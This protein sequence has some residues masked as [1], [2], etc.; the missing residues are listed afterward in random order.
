MLRLGQRRIGGLLG[1]TLVLGMLRTGNAGMGD[2][3]GGGGPGWENSR[4]KGA[5]NWA[6]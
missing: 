6:V 5:Q 2:S 1:R 3:L 4:M